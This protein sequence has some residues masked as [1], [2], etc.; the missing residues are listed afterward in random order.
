MKSDKT[1]PNEQQLDTRVRDRMLASG[2]LDPKALE[3]HLAELPDLESKAE[4]VQIEQPALV[5]SDNE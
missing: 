1:K 5:P 2:A 3:Q 4:T